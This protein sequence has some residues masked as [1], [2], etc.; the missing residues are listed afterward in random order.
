M[1]RQT[2]A[3]SKMRSELGTDLECPGAKDIRK[4]PK[5]SKRYPKDMSG[6]QS[7]GLNIIQEVGFGRDLE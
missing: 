5:E 7:T 2:L 3:K 1:P 4:N 6:G